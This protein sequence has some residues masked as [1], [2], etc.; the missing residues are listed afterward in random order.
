MGS[1]PLPLVTSKLWACGRYVE[2]PIKTRGV[3][4][5]A[6]LND[7]KADRGMHRLRWVCV[8]CVGDAPLSASDNAVTRALVVGSTIAWSMSESPPIQHFRTE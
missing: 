2:R 1:N 4:I 7:D 6:M 5:V 8:C 3:G